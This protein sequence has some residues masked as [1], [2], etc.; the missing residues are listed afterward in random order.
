MIKNSM[1]IMFV[2]LL[3]SWWQFVTQWMNALV[4]TSTV[5]AQSK[6]SE[7]YNKCHIPEYKFKPGCKVL[8]RNLKGD[9]RKGGK[10]TSPWLGPY[11]VKTVYDNNTCVL[12]GDKG[13]L[14]SKQHLCNLKLY[15]ERKLTNETS[16]DDNTVL[17]EPVCKVW[18]KNLNLTDAEKTNNISR[19]SKR[20]NHWCCSDIA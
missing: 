15:K 2:M 7:D 12:T 13:K 11:T 20:Q 3:M 17:S 6:Q 8:L 1:L 19:H 4:T 18:I 14:K 5:K 16:V 9:D 10:N